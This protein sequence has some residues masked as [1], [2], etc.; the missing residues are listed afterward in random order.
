MGWS[1]CAL[2][3]RWGPGSWCPR[4]GSRG[5]EKRHNC[6][7]YTW[8]FLELETGLWFVRARSV[9][10]SRP[11]YTVSVLINLTSHLQVP[12]QFPSFPH[13]SVER[14]P[15]ISATDPDPQSPSCQPPLVTHLK[16][17]CVINR[18]IQPVVPLLNF[19]MHLSLFNLKSEHWEGLKLCNS[20]DRPMAGH[21]R[22]LCIYLAGLNICPDTVY[23]GIQTAGRW[24]RPGQSLL[25]K[26]SRT[27]QKYGLDGVTSSS[28]F[29]QDKKLLSFFVKANKETYK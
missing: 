10:Y 16:V 22:G 27:T 13:F 24:L 25:A 18:L 7:G 1:Q 12:W 26:R 8:T 15:D 29:A 2:Q 3:E 20:K 5:Q 19:H 11:Q 9:F 6:P 14:N 4:W 21:K 23:C 17:A 28:V